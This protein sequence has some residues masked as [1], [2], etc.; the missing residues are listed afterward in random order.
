MP[1]DSFER[2]LFRCEDRD[3]TGMLGSFD[4]RDSRQLMIFAT[5]RPAQ[6]L[7]SIHEQ[8]H[9]EL[10]WST[11]WGLIAA[12]AGLLAEAGVNEQALAPLARKANGACWQVHEVFATTI[13]SGA[14]GV[15]QA[16]RLMAGNDLYLGYLDE[17][18][19]LGGPVD[20]ASW[21]FRE[22]ATQMLLRSL[23]Q[24]AALADLAG[25][26]FTHLRPLDLEPESIHPDFR[27]EAV[28]GEAGTW[29]ADTFAAVLA[30]HPD[31]GGDSGGA[32][33]RNLP[34]DQA[35][36][37]AL[38]SWE[39]TVLIP[40][41][42]ETADARMRTAGFGVL[43]PDEYLEVTAALRDSFLELAPPEWEVEVLAGPRRLRDEALGSEREAVVL[44]PERA[45][46]LIRD[47][48]DL[49]AGP[50]EF[51]HPGEARPRI[52]SL[53]LSSDIIRRQ[54]KGADQLLAP[55]A[56]LGIAGIPRASA[57][58]RTVPIALMRPGV[59]PHDLT[60]MFQSLPVTTV[61]T[62]ATTLDQEAH[63]AVLELERVL[64]LVDLPLRLQV[65]SWIEGAGRVRFRVIE[66]RGD[67]HLNLIVFK[68]DGF[69]QRCFLSFRSDAG[70][71]E[72][73]QLIDRHPER[74]TADLA[75][76]DREL[77][78]IRSVSAW[79]MNAWH[80]LDEIPGPTS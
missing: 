56:V 69:P 57:A 79:L 26:E 12:M 38:K 18:L 48:D 63:D 70:V 64:I 47:A 37:E 73:A 23:M 52:I 59:S 2:P 78:E 36:M 28:A 5:E 42:Q 13:S 29:W 33:Q 72:L 67:R 25:R 76:S 20:A 43:G 60:G 55:M 17:G 50:D 68:L 75:I 35:E 6:L 7:V 24:P 44:H 41:L 49:A 30:E 9:H 19:G 61:T 40:T 62:L 34:D 71:G 10:Q 11:A 58:E 80:R 32:W 46:L 74:L 4:G 16:R 15:P 65:D 8:L 66:L 3:H 45:S 27:L 22:S 14:I 39:E 1:G 21:Q 77:D 51:L 54:F 53:Y 31:R